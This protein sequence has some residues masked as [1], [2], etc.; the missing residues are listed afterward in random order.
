M[1]K[2]YVGMSADLVHQGHINIIKEAAALGD[3]TVG[4]LTD[5]AIATYKRLPYLSY[6][7]RKIVIENISGVKAVVP[8]ESLDYV[9]NLRKYKPDIVVHG[10][11]WKTG[12]QSKTRQ[13][14][15]GKNNG[16]TMINL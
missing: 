7:Q 9:S 13:K 16:V 10:D 14:N 5:A 15:N 12:V 11:D 1:K 6:D 8:Q 3:V 4:L 2:I